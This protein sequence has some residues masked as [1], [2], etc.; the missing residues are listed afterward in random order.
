MKI[1]NL[2]I[3]GVDAIRYLNSDI[4]KSLSKSLEFIS[5][6]FRF[7]GNVSLEFVSNNYI[8]SN[9]PSIRYIYPNAEAIT[10]QDRIYVSLDNIC[11]DNVFNVVIH[12]YVHV[13]IAATF[14]KICPMW[15][16][17]G[18]AV[19]LSDQTDDIIEI[20]PNN[21]ECFYVSTQSYANFYNMSIH[22]VKRLV[23]I[24][25]LQKVG[26][27]A[28]NCKL[29]ETDDLFGVRAIKDLIETT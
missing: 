7:N 2:A 1:K 28:Q 26:E 8:L 3:C 23:T 24:Y 4:I 6:L 17:E 25:G 5:K 19:Y 29:F 20:S 11:T 18:L 27:K 22:V 15:L 16:N 12:E 9:F 13:C 21:V 10:F 14:S